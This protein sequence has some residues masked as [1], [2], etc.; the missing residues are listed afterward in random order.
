MPHMLRAG[1]I[2]DQIYQQ[3]KNYDTSPSITCLLYS[4][5]LTTLDNKRTI[6]L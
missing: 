1:S 3:Q 4:T 5:H 2:K 6:T